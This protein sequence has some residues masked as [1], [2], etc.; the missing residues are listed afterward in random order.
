MLHFFFL[1]F[2]GAKKILMIIKK[3]VLQMCSGPGV[4]KWATKA[5]QTVIT[6]QSG[7]YV[8]LIS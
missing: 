8:H 1:C 2:G 3:Q 5:T 4:H 6:Q 7:W